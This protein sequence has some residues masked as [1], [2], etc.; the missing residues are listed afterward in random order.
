MA[1]SIKLFKKK[2]KGVNPKRFIIIKRK[3]FPLAVVRNK[4]KRRVKAVLRKQPL[5]GKED[6]YIRLLKGVDEMTYSELNT[7]IIEA[8]KTQK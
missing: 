2:M 8:L 6:L 4:I 7:R 3:D 5:S 1:N